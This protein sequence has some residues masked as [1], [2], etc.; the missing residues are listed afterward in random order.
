DRAVILLDY[1]DD[2]ATQ[3]CGQYINMASSI[4]T[5]C[6]QGQIA[7]AGFLKAVK[8]KTK[9]PL[10]AFENK[11]AKELSALAQFNVHKCVPDRICV[12]EP[13][14]RT[15]KK[16]VSSESFIGEAFVTASILECERV[17]RVGSSNVICPIA[18]ELYIFYYSRKRYLVNGLHFIL[19]LLALKILQKLTVPKKA[20]RSQLLALCQST[21]ESRPEEAHLVRIYIDTQIVRLIADTDP[22]IR[23]QI[24]GSADSEKAFYDLRHYA[25]SALRRMREAP[26]F[27]G[28]ILDISDDHDNHAVNLKCSE[29]IVKPYAA[30]AD[31]KGEILELRIREA[32]PY[33]EMTTALSSLQE[34]FSALALSRDAGPRG[35]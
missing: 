30:I 34:D 33:I 7:V 18:D 27:V 16:K 3:R 29:H 10:F 21:L 22:R 19:A 17:F 20:W 23:L 25:E 26:D 13:C 14:G 28:R 32:P 4:S 6:N 15:R 9:L 24:F 8:T 5:S 1:G 2:V 31:R 11:I 35:R 12:F